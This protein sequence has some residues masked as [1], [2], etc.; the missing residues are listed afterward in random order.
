MA[1]LPDSVFLFFDVKAKKG[2]AAGVCS[3]GLASFRVAGLSEVSDVAELLHNISTRVAP[4][5]NKD[6]SDRKEP[7]PEEIEI[8][9]AEWAQCED[10]SASLYKTL[11]SIV[12]AASAHDRCS[13][14]SLTRI[15]RAYCTS[16]ISW[17][18]FWLFLTPF[19][20]RSGIS[21]KSPERPRARS[22]LTHPRGSFAK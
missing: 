11:D 1:A 18:V 7:S 8:W 15:A 21:N 13:V 12:A 2:L 19:H 22:R 14:L 10:F 16:L 3:S 5:Q 20:P 4:A 17:D 6:K 9:Q